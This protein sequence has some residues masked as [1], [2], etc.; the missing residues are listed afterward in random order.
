MRQVMME[1]KQYGKVIYMC[2]I[3]AMHKRSPPVSAWY[4]AGEALLLTSAKSDAAPKLIP[5]G[6]LTASPR[7]EERLISDD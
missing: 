5:R 3:D 7:K 2:D 6:V 4:S 1:G